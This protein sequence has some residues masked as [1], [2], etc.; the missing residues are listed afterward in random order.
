MQ[1]DQTTSLPI[2]NPF[3]RDDFAKLK[4]AQAE[5]QQF[6]GLCDKA[7]RAGIDCSEWRGLCESITTSLEG[8]ETE[9]FTPPPK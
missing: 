4:K 9:F 2:V 7:E 8:I 3:S 6:C 1:H 5:L